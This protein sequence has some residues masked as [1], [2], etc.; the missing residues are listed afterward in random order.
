MRRY[1]PKAMHIAPAINHEKKGG[2][3]KKNYCLLVNPFYPKDPVSSFGKHV[4]T[5]SLALTSFAAATPQEWEVKYWDENLLQGHIPY[6]EI[7]Q[8]V[9]I[10]VHLTFANRA[11]EIARWYRERGSIVVMGGLHIM[12]CPH[13]V[14]D[15]CHIMVKGEGVKIWGEI[16]NDISKGNY[17]DCYEGKFDKEYHLEPA[18]RREILDRRAFL[19]TASVIATRGCNNR[20]GFCYLSTK[21]LKMPY[22]CRHP[23]Q[24]VDEI[25][26]TGEK[27][28]VFI[29]NNLGADKDYL[30]E[31]CNALKPLEI[32]WNA[33]V[34]LDVTDDPELVMEMALSGCIGVFIGFES[35]NTNNIIDQNKKSPRCEDYSK[36]VQMLQD[37]GINVNGSFVLGFDHDT[38]EVFD[39]T[40]KWVEEN[41]L[42]CATFHILTPY[43]GTPLFKQMENEGRILHKDWCKYDTANVVFKPKNMS[44]EELKAGYD[45]IYQDLFSLSSIWKR[46]PNKISS[47][48]AYFAGSLLYKRSNMF[49][50]LLIKNNL[51]HAVWRPLIEISRQKHLRYRKQLAA[52]AENKQ[53]VFVIPGV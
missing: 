46:R 32:I 35:L 6:K 29:D 41:K 52:Q 8:V 30:K 1:Y 45:K 33:A 40:A 39:F 37:V 5:P 20:C 9:A 24:I 53:A 47:S 13:E 7:P 27:Y 44:V 12:A 48:I 22:S 42:A 25:K 51:T 16:L 36:R 10:T 34:T 26:H 18:P 43:P 21:G 3:L 31:L 50:H 2:K 15:H 49:W 4:L 17:K 38:K 19:T 14:R 28:V 23:Q 11:Y